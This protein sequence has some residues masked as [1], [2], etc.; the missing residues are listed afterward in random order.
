[1]TTK[2]KNSIIAAAVVLAIAAGIYFY[3]KKKKVKTKAEQA[4]YIAAKTGAD[5]A[6]LMTFDDDYVAARYN[7]LVKN[8]PAY[9]VKGISY[10]TSNGRAIPVTGAVSAQPQQGIMASQQSA[11]NPKLFF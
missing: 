3:S 2:T 7:A 11:D 9:V 10:F 1:M 6:V 8:E 4:K 5:A